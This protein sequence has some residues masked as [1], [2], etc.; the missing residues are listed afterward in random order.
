MTIMI[1]RIALIFFFSF[2]L[3]LQ[4]LWAQETGVIETDDITVVF[5]RP[6]KNGA[7]E[8]VALYPRIK[9]EL[10]K[11]LDWL[12]DFR[13]TVILVS[14]QERF[15]EMAGSNLVVAYALPQRGLIVLDYSRINAD[16]FSLGTILKHELCH[17]L[18]HNRIQSGNLP[19]WLDEGVSQWVS[20]GIA[21]ILMNRDKSVLPTAVL[22]KKYI[23]IDRLH[24]SFPQ[25]RKS[26]LLA[27][28]ESK[29]LVE[30]ISN[31]YG[32]DGILDILKQLR[33]GHD[34]D[35]AIVNSLSISISELES[36]W[37]SHLRNKITWFTY[38]ASNLYGI[39]FFLAAIIT[40]IAFV[41]V[42]IKR[43]TYAD[44]DL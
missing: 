3:A 21:E 35:A 6:L 24:D 30:Y 25:D 2:F 39:L 17:L 34:V 33:D 32:R 27:Y 41:R 37:H 11:A 36:N 12:V 29:S 7:E 15:Q 14:N 44:E 16:P 40:V 9:S 13:P 1:R 4:V 38:L 10:E 20:D 28:E 31:E 8:I 19:R 18:L 43:R 5:E 26:L 42:L 22:S 23:S